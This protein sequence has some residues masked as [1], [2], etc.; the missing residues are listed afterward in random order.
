LPIFD[1]GRLKA[2]YGATQAQIDSAVS[3]YRET[4]VAAARDVATQAAT[5]AQIAAERAQRL[6]EIDAA[7]RLQ[8]SAAARAGQG[9]TDPRPELSAAES[10]LEQRD[11]LLQLDAA[12]LSAD[13][14]LQRALGGGYES[15][16]AL[17]NSP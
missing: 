10:W 4:V 15:P 11:A 6:I 17:A 9:L 2:R 13:I 14:A 7:A 3:G 12:A 1:A 16:A 8:G 5:R